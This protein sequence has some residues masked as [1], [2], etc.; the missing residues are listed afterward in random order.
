MDINLLYLHAFGWVF[1]A[2]QG[3]FNSL[4]FYLN[5]VKIIFCLNSA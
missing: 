2:A 5:C 3:N 4:G 1:V